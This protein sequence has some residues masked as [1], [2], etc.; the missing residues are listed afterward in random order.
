MMKSGHQE[1]PTAARLSEAK[2]AME[3]ADF[4]LLATVARN[5]PTPQAANPHVEDERAGD[6]EEHDLHEAAREGA[7][8]L[9]RDGE[10]HPAL[11]TPR[12]LG[13]PVAGPVSQA[14]EFEVCQGSLSR[15]V[16]PRIT[17]PQMQPS[18]GASRPLVGEEFLLVILEE[19]PDPLAVL[20]LEVPDAGTVLE[21][22]ADFVAEGLAHLRKPDVAARP[23]KVTE[24][25]V[26]EDHEPAEVRVVEVLAEDEETRILL[27]A[28]GLRFGDDAPVE[29]FKEGLGEFVKHLPQP[30]LELLEAHGGP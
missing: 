21:V 20:A 5:T 4:L 29:V 30:L 22:M 26:V 27:V 6:P 7:E 25:T 14:D 13:N 2:T 18:L 28:P 11:H 12:E 16:L 23:V 10:V 1:P 24:G 15:R 19:T 8:N 9:E 17:P 3:A